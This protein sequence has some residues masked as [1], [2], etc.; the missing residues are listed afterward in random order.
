[1][2]WTFLP[3]SCVIE[4]TPPY[5]VLL[6]GLHPIPCAIEW[7]PPYPLQRT[8]S[9]IEWTLLLMHSTLP[10]AIEWTPPYQLCTCGE[11]QPARN[12]LRD[13]CDQMLVTLRHSLSDEQRKTINDKYTQHL[14]KAKAFRDAYNANIEEAEKEETEGA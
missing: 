9:A 6:S 3:P 14:I 11:I 10:R 1:M 12:D 4:C 2:E 7:T 13:K 5:P 8:A